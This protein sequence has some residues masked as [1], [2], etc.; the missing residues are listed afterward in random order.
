LWTKA[1]AGCHNDPAALDLSGNTTGTG[2]LLSY[3]ELLIGDPVICTNP[4]ATT[5]PCTVGMPII[6]VQEDELVIRR[7]EAQV[8]SGTARGSHL[9][10]VLFNQDLRSDRNL[11]PTNHFNFLNASEKRLVSEWIDLGAQY[12]N[13]PRDAGGALRGVTGLSESAF[14]STVHPIL[15][16]RCSS[17]HQAVG[18]PGSGGTVPNPGFV[19]KR[20]V[21][22]GQAEGD[23]NVTLSMIS[24]VAN[25]GSNA[26]LRR[27]AS[28]G[29]NP[30]HGVAIGGGA[31]LPATDPDYRTICNWIQSGACP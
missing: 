25:P 1:C 8:N 26:L 2:R 6:D 18:L 4:A 7:E 12:Y 9:I 31:V 17:C 3:D 5:P 27:P 21:L 16:N 14:N 15:L 30:T 28:T 13:S 11:G 22:T 29:T 23:F 20:F 24:N 10:E 19:G